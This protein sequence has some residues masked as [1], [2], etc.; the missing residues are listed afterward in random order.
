MYKKILVPLDGSP[1]AE[2]VLPHAEALAKLEGAE[3]VILRV[4]ATPTAEYFA[5]DP[6]IGESIRQDIE[7]EAKDYV[8]K[9][10]DALKNDQIRVTGI[11]QEGAVPET[12]LA[13][14]DET[15][16]DMIA[17]STHGRTGV[18]RWL[19]GSVADRVVHYAHIPVMLIH[20]N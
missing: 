5:R 9:A 3:I 20:P 1:L 17:M 8:N 6:V 10:V 19:M 13:V 4:P 2:T 16:A 15:H 12:I 11:V 7:I 18:S 14:A